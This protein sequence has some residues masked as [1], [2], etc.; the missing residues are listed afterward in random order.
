[1]A[2]GRLKS[3]NY[4]QK[5]P[6]AGVGDVDEFLN[7]PNHMRRADGR[8]FPLPS[9]GWVSRLA[10]YDPPECAKAPHSMMAS[11]R[12]HGCNLR[13]D[14]GTNSPFERGESCVQS[15]VAVAGKGWPTGALDDG[16]DGC[17]LLSDCTGNR[18]DSLHAPAT[19][20]TGIVSSSVPAPSNGLTKAT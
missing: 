16:C 2:L 3:F 15:A 17:A 19:T 18:A 12:G 13:C 6:A 8:P 5:A 20:V 10:P 11:T 4:L 7:L 1:M 14:I 9:V